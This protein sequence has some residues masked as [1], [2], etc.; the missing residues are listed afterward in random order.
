MLHTTAG[1]SLDVDL[2][3]QAHHGD[4]WSSLDVRG[5]VVCAVPYETL[6]FELAL[7]QAPTPDLLVLDLKLLLL[8]L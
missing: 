2:A 7:L 6:G 8:D 5:R 1:H 4:G 3:P